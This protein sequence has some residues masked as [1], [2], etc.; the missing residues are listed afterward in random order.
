MI[1]VPLYCKAFKSSKKLL[2]NK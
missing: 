2:Y 1:L